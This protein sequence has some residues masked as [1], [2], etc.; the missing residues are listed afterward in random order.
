MTHS[1]ILKQ[2]LG[3]FKNYSNLGGYN[4]NKN[5]VP[6]NLLNIHLMNGI[7]L[8]T[9]KNKCECDH[10]IMKNHFIQHVINKKIFIVGTCCIKRFNIKKLCIT[11]NKPHNRRK[12]IECVECDP[13]FINPYYSQ[14]YETPREKNKN[15]INFGKYKNK[16]I[17]Y[18]YQNDKSYILWCVNKYSKEQNENDSLF[19]NIVDYVKQNQS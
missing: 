12:F 6:N 10:S 8:P 4:D 1:T 2:K 7:V 3:D 16:T 13:P 14:F 9:L 5:E 15:I 19:K 18:V 11:C 17:E